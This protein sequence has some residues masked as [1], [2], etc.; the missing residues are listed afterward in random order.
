MNTVLSDLC[1]CGLVDC[2]LS[3]LKI[4]LQD[5]FTF[6]GYFKKIVCL[7]LQFAALWKK[8]HLRS[9]LAPRLLRSANFLEMGQLLALHSF[10]CPFSQLSVCHY[11][12]NTVHVNSHD[13]WSNENQWFVLESQKEWIFSLVNFCL[14]YIVALFVIVYIDN[15]H[16]AQALSSTIK[17]KQCIPSLHSVSHVQSKI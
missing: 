4:L 16:A 5:L 9:I 2:I 12:E 3:Q 15:N 10:N 14:E 13:P 11:I 6:S 17:S 7:V 1:V 8:K